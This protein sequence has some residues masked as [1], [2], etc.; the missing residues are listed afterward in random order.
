MKNRTAPFGVIDIGSNSVR[1]VIYFMEGRFP[2]PMVNDKIMCGLGRGLTKTGRLHAG[3]MDRALGAL[4]RFR[5]VA[6]AMGARQVRAAA[7][8]AV[9]DAENG[10]EFVTEAK[11]VS[12]FTVEVLTG[13]A[14]AELAARGVLFGIPDADGL[15]GD[16]GGGSLELVSIDHGAPGST[17]TLPI[18][19]LRLMDMFGR[20][21]NRTAAHLD[22]VFDEVIW[23]PESRGKPFFAVGGIWRSFA[24][25]VMAESQYPLTV[26]HQ[27][28]VP[29]DEVF[30]FAEFLARQS[31]SSLA[32]IPALSSKRA[33]ALPH[34][35]LIL[36]RLVR[37]AGLTE[38]IVS[39]YGLREGLLMEEIE[40]RRRPHDPLLDAARDWR[41][42]RSRTPEMVDELPGFI[43]AL[44][45]PD[46]PA[47]KRLRLAACLFS[48][49]GWQAHPDYR[50]TD[51]FD[52]VLT[53]PIA[54]LDHRERVLLALA[55][56]HRYGGGAS[57]VP[58]RRAV[59][60]LL[61]EEEREQA[62]RL[63][64]ALR[65]AYRL[66]GAAKGVLPRTVLSVEEGRL[67]LRLPDALRDFAG[68]GVDKRLGALASAMGLSPVVECG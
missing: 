49:I 8:A 68:E 28:R 5:A 30:T 54:G 12:G 22:R 43:G 34:G 55:L 33:D 38:L 58:D 67:V 36:D 44:P 17:V 15:A 18:G 6:D 53:A 4:R 24:R 45:W 37:K 23:L 7:T 32:R 10:P 60:R 46:D 41:D 52:T 1:M 31:P 20:K 35:A 13:E 42:T 9:R 56:W 65:L 26:L 16:L 21:M 29:A 59:G 14:E 40:G 66:S 61:V 62:R 2:V 51:I 19:P 64:L 50:G 63:G 11:H 47:S 3:G 27:F 57:D 39:A 48:D 25:V